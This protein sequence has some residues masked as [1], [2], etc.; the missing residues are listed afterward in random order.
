MRVLATLNAGGGKITYEYD[1]GASWIHEIAL[2]KHEIA[3]QKKV[4]QEPGAGYP[5][6]VKYSSDST[7]E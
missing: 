1:F 7:I 6:C 3:L 5:F 2:Q 4:P